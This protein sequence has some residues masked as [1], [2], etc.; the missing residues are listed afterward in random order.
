L[1]KTIGGKIWSKPEMVVLVR[2]M[3]GEAVLSGCKSPESRAGGKPQGYDAN[4]NKGCSVPGTPNCGNC[5]S[6]NAT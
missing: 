1:P 3:P 6:R 2:N 5:Q 4:F